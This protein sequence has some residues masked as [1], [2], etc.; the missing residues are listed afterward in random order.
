MGKF[1]VLSRSRCGS[2]LL[3][4]LLRN[5]P[6][7]QCRGEVLQ[8]IDGKPLK[9]TIDELFIPKQKKTKVIGFKYFYYHPVDGDSQK[10]TEILKSIEELKVIHLKRRNLLKTVISCEIA[11]L[12]GVWYVND[13]TNHTEKKPIEISV[14][15]VKEEID[16]TNSRINKGDLDFAANPNITVFYEDLVDNRTTEFRKI[17]DFL[18]VSETVPGDSPLKKQNPEPLDKLVSN[19]QE[20]INSFKGTKYEH[21]L[22]MNQV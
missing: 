2:N 18:N 14:E 10:A 8:R 20:I 6:E 13:K 17:L 3:V 19:F 7:I 16:L 1:I 5:C 21:Y 15:K 9:T 11:E 12:T 4:S 22:N